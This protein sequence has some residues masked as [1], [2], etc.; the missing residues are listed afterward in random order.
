MQTYVMTRNHVLSRVFFGLFLSLLTGSAGVY[1]GTYMPPAVIGILM[2]VELVMIV[3]AMFIQRR[4]AVG[5]PFVLVFTFVTGAT[6]WP[7]ISFYLANI[8]PAPVIKALAVSA[9]AFLVA[10]AV[11]SRSSFDFTFLGG[12]LFIGLLALLLMGLVS[13][14]LPFSS[15]VGLVYSVLGIAV[16][17]G[18]VLFDVNRIVHLGL[19]DEMVPWVVLSLYLD[20]VNLFLFVLRLFG[21]LQSDRR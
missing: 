6:L 8:G 18:Y 11:A 15:T 5:M 3:A 17:V 14:F 20:F 13:F 19:S 12:F 2:L 10:A 9:A 4:R 7:A 1:A 21:I 16:F